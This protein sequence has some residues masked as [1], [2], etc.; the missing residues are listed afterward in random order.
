[1]G[2][3]KTQQFSDVA[4]AP[5]GNKTNNEL[6]EWAEVRMNSKM[7]QSNRDFVKESETQ[8][9]LQSCLP[10]KTVPE[11]F[12]SNLDPDNEPFISI[13]VENENADLPPKFGANK[14]ADIPCIE[15]E[16]NLYSSSPSNILIWG[17][18]C[19]QPIRV[20]VDTGAAITV[21]SEQFYVDALRT[22]FAMKK[23]D[24]IDSIK[25]ANGSTVSV[26]GSVNFP[27]LLGDQEY[28]CDATI[29]P[30]L[31]YNVVLGRDFLH[32]FGAVINVRGCFVT[33]SD[34]N[35]VQF[36]KGDRPTFVSDVRTTTTY[37]IDAQS[38]VVIPARLDK[39]CSEPMIGLI[40]ATPKLSDRYRLLSASSLSAPTSEGMVSFRILNPADKPVLLYK[41]ASIGT[42]VETDA[43]DLIL[44]VESKPEVASIDSLE[45]DQNDDLLAKFQSLPSPA[46]SVHENAQLND[47]LTSYEDIFAKSSLD[48]GRT[49]IIEH[50]ID[51]GD[52]RPIKQSPYRVSQQQRAE[53]DKHISDMLEQDIIQV[54]S[55]PWSSP[56]VL[57][58]KKDGTTRFC[59]DYRKLNAVTRKDSYPLPRIDDALDSLSACKYF[60]T[61][62][63]QSGYHQVAIHPDSKDK[64]AFITHAG[65]YEYNVLSFGLTGAPPNF[66]RLMSRILHGLEWKICLIYIDDIIIFSKSFEEHLSRLS[67]VFQRLREAN[68]KLKPSKCHFARN[69][70]NFLGFVVSSD[71]V[72]PDPD[73][74]EAVRSFPVPKCVKDVRSFLGLCNYYRR[75]VE[76]FA[77]ITSPL[78]RL[79]RKNVEFVWSPDCDFAFNELKNRLCSPPI[80][81]YPDFEKPF[82]LYTDASK[83]SIGYVLG[84]KIDGKEH[85][86]AYGGRELNLA[87]TRYSTTEREALAVV[88][89]I[90][91][92]Q[93]YLSGAKFYVHTDHGSLS[94]LMNVKDPTGRL[95]RWALQ[96]QQYDFEI[97]HR[98]GSS[99]GNAD[100]LSRRAYPSSE[101][102]E[103]SDL[104]PSVSLPVASIDQPI[105]SIQSLHKLQRQDKDLSDIIQYLEVATLPAS[106]TKARSLLLSI[107]SYYLDENGILCHLWSPGKRRVQSICSQVVIP[108]SLRH[109]ILVSCHDDPT[110]GH[111]GVLKTYEKVRVRYYWHGM[112]KDIE[113]WCNSC[114]DC[115]MKKIPRGKRKAPLLPIPVEGAFDRVAMDI[116]GPFPVTNDGNRYIIVFSDY[117]TRWPEAFAMPSIE[118]PR[119]AQLLVDEILARHGAPRTLL[120]DRGS[121]FLSSIVTEV[122]RIM[123]TRKLH[124]TAYHPQTDGL[125]ERF[126]GTLAE[127]LSMYVSTNQKDWD[128]HIP[129]ILFAYRVSPNA[130]THES[131]FYLLYGREPRL[132][133]DVALLLPSSKLSTSI[134]EHRARIVQ[135]VENAQRII[136]S[137]TQL[138]QQRM[139]E[140]YDKTAT[141]VDFDIGSKVWVYTPKKRKGLSKKLL[142]NYH[143]P[144][145]VV[146]KL[147]PVH[148]R[149]RTLDNRPVSV[150][151]H[152]NRMKPFYDPADRPIVPPDIESFSQDLADSDLPAESFSHDEELSTNDQ[153]EEHVNSNVPVSDEPQITRPEDFHFPE[154]IRTA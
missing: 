7:K 122:C 27:V 131:P 116:L 125:V 151:V 101:P 44:T 109:E 146:T 32:H 10:E 34:T 133:I 115:A 148:F 68:L 154:L 13:K 61:L 11:I 117:Y 87:E 14:N 124:T 65:L 8:N 88:D 79:T 152:A 45:S 149:L 107:D 66:Q 105:P 123:D 1:M 111:L 76:G 56:V 52:A 132:P 62:D 110:A 129:M 98:P 46:L 73:K 48:L 81:A 100:A 42:F 120:S 75:F 97:L 108:A 147:S 95:A 144:Y 118:A 26:S 89:G 94:W 24:K 28:S 74:I 86:V 72:S 143:G 127:G 138:A 63:L 59:I 69:S 21:V 35:V 6:G 47:L 140:Q 99:N 128:R 33:F 43:E 82:H 31:A 114:V 80:L 41:G 50:E 17:T 119:V 57:V 55:S 93:P 113:H 9:S 15:L 12:D 20:L 5:N 16:G 139:K 150:P 106:D 54:S 60:S 153:S 18:V 142:H 25:T 3:L 51:T 102:L 134:R 96:L 85:V 91:R 53:I 22:N 137:N 29:V 78:N 23:S 83:S 40:V 49:S 121:N 19:K 104:M 4:K 136:S 71:G 84:Q 112:F 2:K 77:K 36:I 30:G 145:R 103:P 58:K 37:V 130:T 38:E 141:P 92:Y 135:S 126:N 67:L 39:S 64:T 90:K 70:V